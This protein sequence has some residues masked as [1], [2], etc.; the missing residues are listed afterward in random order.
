MAV[1]PGR[2]FAGGGHDQA[3]FHDGCGI[4]LVQ[5]DQQTAGVLARDRRPRFGQP[6]QEFGSCG[7]IP[8]GPDRSTDHRHRVR[9]ARSVESRWLVF[10]EHNIDE[11]PGGAGHR[12]VDGG[13]CFREGG[14]AVGI[15]RSGWDQALIERHGTPLTTRGTS[16]P[17]R[18]THRG[19]GRCRRV[20]H[21]NRE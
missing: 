13:D 3:G 15:E 11:P 1:H 16:E 21:R 4:D 10:G 14:P 18:Q 7:A 2:L 19:T 9:P 6:G 5:A 12:G 20:R 8:A 17:R